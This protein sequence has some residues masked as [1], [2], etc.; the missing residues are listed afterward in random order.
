MPRA[1]LGDA[2]DG[3]VRV[4]AHIH[5]EGRRHCVVQQAVCRADGQ[6]TAGVAGLWRQQ[7]GV[8]HRA[9]AEQAAVAARQ[10]RGEC[11]VVA[12]D[13]PHFGHV[14]GA[15]GG[16]IGNAVGAVL[17]IQQRARLDGRAAASV[18]QGRHHRFGG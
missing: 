11:V 12:G 9:G 15:G 2:V 6:R 3:A 4:P 14:Q 1:V 7:A 8:G 13:G 5:V 18:H 16:V 10:G 17:P